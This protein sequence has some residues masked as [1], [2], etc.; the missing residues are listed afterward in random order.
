MQ[1]NRT[2]TNGTTDTTS[3]E[4]IDATLTANAT[5][6]EIQC[7]FILKIF[8]KHSIAIFSLK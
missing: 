6:S 8:Y 5:G 7:T 3:S 1:R 2:K 4:T